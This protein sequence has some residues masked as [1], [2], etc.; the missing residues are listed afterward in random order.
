MNN[1]TDIGRYWF[2][3]VTITKLKEKCI[4]NQNVDIV[5]FCYKIIIWR[6]FPFTNVPVH[7]PVCWFFILFTKQ[8]VTTKSAYRSTLV[9]V[10]KCIGHGYL[11]Y[12]FTLLLLKQ[13]VC[14]DNWNVCI[15]NYELKKI[16]NNYIHNFLFLNVLVLDILYIFNLHVHLLSDAWMTHLFLLTFKIFHTCYEII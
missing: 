11:H 5:Y 15:I 9:F 10:Y 2:A 14:F 4:I 7:L 1:I 6:Y 8:R 13:M 3:Q 16:T 12:H